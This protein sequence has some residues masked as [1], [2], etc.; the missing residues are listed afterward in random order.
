M[1][2]QDD[3]C[4][5]DRNTKRAQQE[6]AKLR[7]QADLTTKAWMAYQ[8]VAACAARL[9]RAA[10]LYAEEGKGKRREFIKASRALEK[11]ADRQLAVFWAMD[12]DQLKQHLETLAD[13]QKSKSESKLSS[14]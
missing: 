2:D 4:E 3:E 12:D 10:T 11:A 14:I 9:G 6:A 8:H 1:T 5:V 13:F 7:G